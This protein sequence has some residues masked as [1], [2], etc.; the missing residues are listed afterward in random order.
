MQN[1]RTNSIDVFALGGFDSGWR[2]LLRILEAP[3]IISNKCNTES[4]GMHL[5]S[6]LSE[7]IRKVHVF[8]GFSPP[9]S[10]LKP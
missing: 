5:L 8:S 9:V 7:V 10:S 1:V 2:V 3:Y 4:F 6:D